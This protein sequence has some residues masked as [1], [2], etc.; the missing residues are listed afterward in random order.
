MQ[1]LNRKESGIYPLVYGS[2][3]YHGNAMKTIVELQDLSY[4][5]HHLHHPDHGASLKIMKIHWTD[6]IQVQ[7]EMAPLFVPGLAVPE[8]TAVLR[9]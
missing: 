8:W 7:Q 3:L 2:G 9:A 1:I 4:H 6:P 5:N